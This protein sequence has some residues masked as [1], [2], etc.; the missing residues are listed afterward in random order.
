MNKIIF[1]PILSGLI[2]LGEKKTIISDN[3]K[4][5]LM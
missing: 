4:Y 5:S 2:K 1:I 3:R